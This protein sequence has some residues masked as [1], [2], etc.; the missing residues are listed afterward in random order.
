MKSHL[1]AVMCG[2]RNFLSFLQVSAAFQYHTWASGFYSIMRNGEYAK[3][4]APAQVC[5]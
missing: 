1:G 5:V 3:N 2:T 4:G